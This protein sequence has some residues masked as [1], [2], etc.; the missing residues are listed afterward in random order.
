MNLHR[1]K[2][3]VKPGPRLPRL[4]SLLT[5]RQLTEQYPHLFTEGSLRWTIFCRE[6]NGFDRCIV[7]VGRRIFID[8]DQLRSW[9]AE[10]P[11]PLHGSKK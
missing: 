8:T 4:D 1:R 11:D 6:E 5:V 2:S 9:M 3:R 7:R 10:H